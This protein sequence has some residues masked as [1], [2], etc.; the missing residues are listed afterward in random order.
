M[1]AYKNVS[2][3]G[4][5]SCVY[6]KIMESVNALGGFTQSYRKLFLFICKKK[7]AFYSEVPFSVSVVF[8]LKHNFGFSRFTA[9]YFLILSLPVPISI[10]NDSF[11]CWLLQGRGLN[12]YRLFFK[13]FFK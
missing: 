11:A 2:F 12:S 7:T 8:V 10:L 4:E 1:A 3:N 13:S 6:G 9:F 5:L